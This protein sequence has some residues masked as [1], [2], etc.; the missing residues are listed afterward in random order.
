[1]SRRP[2][3]RNCNKGKGKTMT[4]KLLKV[5]NKSMANAIGF[6][7]E[8]CHKIYVVE[9]EEEKKE[10]IGYGYKIYP[11]TKLESVFR[12]SCFLR[13][14]SWGD[15]NKPCIVPQ[16]ARQVTFTYNTGKSVVRFSRA[17]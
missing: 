6:G 9:T 12:N 4:K 13:F 8:G 5:G 2:L 1:M 14:I 10:L 11:M 17:A 16:C 15:L 7:Y 3:T